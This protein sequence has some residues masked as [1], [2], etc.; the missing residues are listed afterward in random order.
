[1]PHF[2]LRSVLLAGLALL[3]SLGFAADDENE[4]V[5]FHG[6]DVH[7]GYPDAFH[8]GYTLKKSNVSPNG[9]YGL[10]FPKIEHAG[11]DYFIVGLQP[12]RI[13]GRL[14]TNWHHGRFSV[15]WA[16]DSSA[17]FFVNN[18][19]WSPM[20]ILAIELK[21]GHASRQTDVLPAI[22][23]TLAAAIG[24]AEHT[25]SEEASKPAGYIEKVEWI[26]QPRLQVLLRYKG[27]TNPKEFEGQSQWKGTL[28]AVWDVDQARFVSQMITGESFVSVVK[29][30]E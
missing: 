4:N 2:I 16:P 13:L 21:D 18:A 1:M 15:H 6:P 3:P 22:E 30:V 25:S 5:E 23:R 10:I 7:P 27:Y 8:V 14:A 12:D 24:K 26:L 11:S 20:G 19:K 9:K 28:E 29:E 17:V